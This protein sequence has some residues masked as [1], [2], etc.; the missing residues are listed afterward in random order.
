MTPRLVELTQAQTRTSVLSKPESGAG[1]AGFRL[2]NIILL[3]S[4]SAA[5]AFFNT[6]LF[7]LSRHC[8]NEA[9]RGKVG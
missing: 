7:R 1:V 8:K 2:S 6:H 4:L 5:T 3:L 9:G